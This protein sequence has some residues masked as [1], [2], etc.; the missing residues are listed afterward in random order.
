MKRNIR[1]TTKDSIPYK[2]V[3]DD[4]I[5]E[6][7]DGYF[8]KA[9]ELGE[10]NF[11]TSSDEEQ[12]RIYR[13]YE[14]LIDSIDE[15]A[16]MQIVI[17]NQKEN[18]KR[19]LLEKVLFSPEQDSLNARRQ[20]VN[21][22]ITNRVIK[23]R[24]G[25]KQEKQL[26][27]SVAEEDTL[28]AKA[29]LDA[30]DSRIALAMRRIL[31]SL[32]ADPISTPDRLR[33]L[34]DIYNQD[35]ESVFE[36][37]RKKSD[38]SPTFSLRTMH[39]MGQTTK[40]V[41]APSGMM[42]KNNFFTLG[43]AYGKAMAL[44]RIPVELTT[45]FLQDIVN[46]NCSSVVS[47]IFEPIKKA[48]A[49]RMIKNQNTALEAE[50][51]A[52]DGEAPFSLENAYRASLDL[53]NDFVNRRQKA[54]Y[55]TLSVCIFADSK[56]ALDDAAKQLC[57]VASGRQ[58]PIRT[59]F[60]RQEAGLNTCLPLGRNYI[61]ERKF[62][63]TETAAVFFPFTS[64]ELEQTN[65]LNYG[66]NQ[67]SKNQV[68]YNRLSNKNYNGLYYGAPGTGKSGQ[69]KLEQLMVLMKSSKNT[70][71]IIDPKGEYVDFA[72]Q[73]GGEVINVAAGTKT[74]MNPLD[75]DLSLADGVD[76]LST[77]ADFLLGLVEIMT[78]SNLTA[79]QAS[80]VDRCTRRIYQPY[81]EHMDTL[82]DRTIDKAASPTLKDL[83]FALKEQK[84]PEAKD[85]AVAI[86]M[87]AIG[88]LQI[89]SNRTN[90]DTSRR[91]IVYDIS[92]L[93]AGARNL[94]LY[95]CLNEIYN[96]TI[97]NRKKDFWTWT[98]IDEMQSILTSVSATRFLSKI[99]AMLRAFNGVPTGIMQNTNALLATQ[100]GQ[101][102]MSNTNFIMALGLS[103]IDRQNLGEFLHLSEAELAVLTDPKPGCGLL[104]AGALRIPIDNTLDCDEYPELYSLIK[105][106][107]DEKARKAG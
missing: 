55:V 98:Y 85:I 41:V 60:A 52:R 48:T 33:F 65:G 92:K 63:T 75:L 90:V 51:S 8:S 67:I 88:N 83:Y 44:Q 19:E 43:N 78:H 70:V 36:N 5:I 104:C 4:G 59:V 57:A 99:W 28:R 69:A 93:G 32:S 49:I 40:D 87:Y 17:K 34:F 47:I 76:P 25:L 80:I 12:L 46:L 102:I 53:M 9:Y 82:G 10:V 91:L 11:E 74:F 35:G 37:A 81:I 105:T 58:A 62:A 103:Q 84:E 79:V 56:K 107:G 30:M 2:L 61:E 77:K 18:S 45:E 95:V 38:D 26:I 6:T 39:K 94:G 97:E 29:A 16:T 27:I 106:S 14:Q 64:L 66:T 31:P 21:K 7:E 13:A 72:R 68:F 54:Y 73:L 89:F 20:Q 101:E 1:K 71:L 86:E 42:F 3:Y 24:N 22:L 15:N 96:K 50:R 100:E 23:G